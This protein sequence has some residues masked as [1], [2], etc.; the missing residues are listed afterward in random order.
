MN[1][2]KHL[3]SSTTKN[4]ASHYLFLYHITMF[5]SSITTGV[6]LTPLAAE[7]RTTKPV[8]FVNGYPLHPFP[9]Y[10]MSGKGTVTRVLCVTFSLLLIILAYGL[11]VFSPTYFTGEY[12]EFRLRTLSLRR[13]SFGKNPL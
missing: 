9:M 13:V 12:S 6:G 8:R 1:I 7:T 4:L 11:Y 2:H 10:S 3:F 5:R